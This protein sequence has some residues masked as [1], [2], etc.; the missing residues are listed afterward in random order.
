[1]G[2]KIYRSDALK[3]DPSDEVSWPDSQ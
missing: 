3:G 1:M 2:G